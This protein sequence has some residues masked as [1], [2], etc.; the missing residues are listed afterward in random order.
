MDLGWACEAKEM[1]RG[2][3][4]DE[5][6]GSSGTTA[7]TLQAAVLAPGRRGGGWNGRRFRPILEK[8]AEISDILRSGLAGI[9][10]RDHG[11]PVSAPPALPGLPEN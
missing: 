9:G 3:L 2:P 7:T 6:S 5:R 11:Q 8:I 10:R 1:G 4:A